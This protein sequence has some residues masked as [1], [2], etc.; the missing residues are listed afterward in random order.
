MAFDAL[1]GPARARLGGVL[2]A[3]G[4]AAAAVAQDFGDTPYVQTP[5]NIVDTMLDIAKVRAGDYVI[6]LGSGDGRLVITAAKKYGARGFGVDLDRRL[7]ELGNA[8]AAKAGVANRAA[9]YERDLHETDVSPATIVTLYLLPE[10]NLMIRPK[11]LATLRPGTRIVSHDYH[12]GVWAPDYQTELDAPRKTV[13]SN[14]RSKIFYWMVPGNAAGRWYWTVTRDGKPVVFELTLD[15]MFQKLAGTLTIGAH[16]ASLE[17]V[18]LEGNRIEFVA[19]SEVGSSRARYEFSGRIIN[20]VIEGR[21]RI[22]HGEQRQELSWNAAR[23]EWWDPRHIAL[24]MVPP[25]RE[26]GVR[27][28][29]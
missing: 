9:F 6:D 11:L 18:K 15:Q 8:N 7:V 16:R 29:P 19:E 14:K 26:M 22:V 4:L 17:S 10:V 23:I 12:M 13:G 21:G 2:L 24:R 3:A 28:A 5:Q 1:I 27:C 25:C 20:H